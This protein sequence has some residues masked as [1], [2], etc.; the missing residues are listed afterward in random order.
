MTSYYSVFYLLT[1]EYFLLASYY[2][3]KISVEVLAEDKN[4]DKDGDNGLH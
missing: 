4:T 1:T 2:L 3:I